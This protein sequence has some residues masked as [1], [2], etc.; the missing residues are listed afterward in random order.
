MAGTLTDRERTLDPPGNRN[1]PPRSSLANQ[2]LTIG[3]NRHNA[4]VVRY[5]EEFLMVLKFEKLSFE[6]FEPSGGYQT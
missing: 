4:G 5:L 2:R 1:A 3:V 6:F